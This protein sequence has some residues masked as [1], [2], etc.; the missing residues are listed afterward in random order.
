MNAKIEIKSTVGNIEVTTGTD[1][2][3]VRD[4]VYSFPNGNIIHFRSRNRT[5]MDPPDLSWKAAYMIS[6]DRGRLDFN[7]SDLPVAV[8]TAPHE[9][10][11]LKA[12]AE[13]CSIDDEFRANHTIKIVPSKINTGELK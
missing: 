9:E 3:I 12:F 1:G 4:Y 6:G 11:I 8:F 7:P 5:Y 13:V 10:M 2:E